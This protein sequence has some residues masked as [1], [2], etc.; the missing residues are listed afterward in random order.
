MNPS[1]QTADAGFCRI[2]PSSIKALTFDMQGSLLDFYGTIVEVGTKVIG[3]R[4]LQVD[5]G[6]AWMAQA[7]RW[8]S[9]RGPWSSARRAGSMSVPRTTSTPWRRA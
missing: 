1:R 5:R 2:D 9:F 3:N 6:A 8:P 4:D 7:S